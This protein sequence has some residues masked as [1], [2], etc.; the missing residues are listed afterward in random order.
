VP[1]IDFG[2][3]Y[4]TGYKNDPCEGT[5]NQDPVPNNRGAYIRGHFI[6]YFPIDAQHHPSDDNCDFSTITP[7]VGVLTR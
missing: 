4:V 1:L 2:Y 7:C 5:A 3:F 6:K